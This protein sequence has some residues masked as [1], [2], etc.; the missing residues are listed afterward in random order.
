MILRMVVSD[1]VC[2]AFAGAC[3]LALISMVFW[4]DQWLA[5]ILS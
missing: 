5:L 4:W 3:G 1:W 2:L